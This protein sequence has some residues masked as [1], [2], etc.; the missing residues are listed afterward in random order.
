MAHRA[1]FVI[2]ENNEARAF[3]DQW[4][5]AT[6]ALALVDGPD[7]ARLGAMDF[8][9]T[10]GLLD[11]GEAEAGYLLDFDQSI[12]IVFGRPHPPPDDDSLDPEMREM[13]EEL[14][15]KIEAGPKAFFEHIESEWQ[16]WRLVW[17]ERGTDGFAEHLA[18]RGMSGVGMPAKNHPS[19]VSPPVEHRVPG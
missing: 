4:A 11:W 8:E 15:N 5:A 9:P 18:S 10:N 12:C 14:L 1:N 7:E 6:T 17:D 3:Y 2:I 19:D 16:G 13:W